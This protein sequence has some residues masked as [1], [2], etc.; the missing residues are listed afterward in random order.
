MT[1]E[2]TPKYSLRHPEEI[3]Q[4][5]ELMKQM[6]VLDITELKEGE[7][8]IMHQYGVLSLKSLT[9]KDVETLVVYRGYMKEREYG[10]YKVKEL[11]GSQNWMFK[12]TDRKDNVAFYHYTEPVK[13]YNYDCLGCY[14]DIV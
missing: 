11:N 7:R 4:E 14:C 10:F 9:R 13:L 1:T 12:E 8:Y 6:M 5:K 3:E 2:I